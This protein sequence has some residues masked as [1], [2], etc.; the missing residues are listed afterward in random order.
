MD[1]FDQMIA[2]FMEGKR[3]NAPNPDVLDRDK[4]IGDISEMISHRLLSKEPT[5]LAVMGMWGVGKT[6]ILNEIEKVFSGKCIIFHYD[7]W[8]NDYYQEPLVGILSVIAEQLNAIEAENPDHQQGHYYDLMRQLV[9]KMSQ[10]VI[11]H[12]TMANVGDI[13]NLFASIK[14]KIR[15][16][17][18][19]ELKPFGSLSTISDVIEVINNLL[20]GYMAYEGKKI[21]FVVDELDR[22]LPDYSLKVLNRLHHICSETPLIQVV[23]INDKELVANINGLYARNDEEDETFAKSYL[24]RFFT[25]FYRIP[26]GDSRELLKHCWKDINKYFYNR[27]DDDF[28]DLFLGAVLNNSNYTIR[29]KKMI[30]NLFRNYHI[31]TLGPSKEKY[32]F[33]L[34]CAEILEVFRLF[35]NLE[36]D[37]EWEDIPSNVLLRS[38]EEVMDEDIDG[39]L[40]T[41]DE[42]LSRCTLSIDVH[43]DFFNQKIEPVWNFFLEQSRKKNES[44]EKGLIPRG[45]AMPNDFVVA[46]FPQNLKHAEVDSLS[47]MSVAIENL[48]SDEE[49]R[50]AFDFFEAFRNKI[51]V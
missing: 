33:E 43:R 32:P 13:S 34:A 46:F 8:K 2:E 29:E 16:K 36:Q 40:N 9:A 38:G 1:E 11:Q 20:C 4:V 31:Q 26:V 51:C 18:S 35:F 41:V 5:S 50:K 24:Q 45:A 10:C 27:T 42:G 49:F 25:D 22:C 17:K 21:L 12:F 37:W 6:F 23:A 14:E 48:K 44:V 7:C 39:E 47:E 3:R 19:I 28:F 15:Q 30:L